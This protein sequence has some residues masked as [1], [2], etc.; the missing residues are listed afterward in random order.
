[1][2]TNS[3]P[4]HPAAPATPTPTPT[5]PPPQWQPL[6]WSFPFAPKNGNLADPQTWLT[7]LASADGGF[8]PLGRN[9]MFHGGF[10][11]MLQP[12]VT[13]SRAMGSNHCR[14]RGCSLQAGFGVSRTNLSD[15]ATP[16][17]AVFDGVCAGYKLVLPPAPKPAGSPAGASGASAPAA[18]P[19]GASGAQTSKT[20]QPPA[21]E[22]LEFY[23]LYMHQLDWAGYQAAEQAGSDSAPSAPSIHRLPFWQGD[24]LFRV[25]AKAKDKS[26]VPPAGPADA[27]QNANTA[28]TG[29]RIC[30]GVSV[31]ATAC[32]SPARRRTQ[33][34]RQ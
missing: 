18:T 2:A 12:A 14:W 26:P 9:G 7:A 10:T 6:N 23:S 5:P 22:V 25:G 24:Q 20:Y 13:L 8:Y 30:Y 15:H 21:D 3:H 19:A 29:A 4:H 33:H 11:S 1:M 28:Q 32:A 34:R 27:S 17:R 31:W 16:L